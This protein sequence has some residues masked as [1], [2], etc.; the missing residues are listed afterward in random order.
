MDANTYNGK[1]RE[2][3]SEVGKVDRKWQ[4]YTKDDVHL[5]DQNVCHSQ[6]HEIAV[7]EES[8]QDKIF[9]FIYELDENI[10][11]DEERIKSLRSMSDELRKRVK[12]NSNEVKA[13]L[14]DLIKA[15]E[16]A[17]PM[18]AYEQQ[19]IDLKKNEH[20]ARKNEKSSKVK[21]K[22]DL[23]H[24]DANSLIAIMENATDVEEMSDQQIR[25]SILNDFKKWEDKVKELKKATEAIT[26][27]LAD[28]DL[29]VSE[30]ELVDNLHEAYQKAEEEVTKRI[31]SLTDKDS[32]LGLYTL[33]PSKNKETI[34]YPD[35]FCGR[36]GENVHKF[37]ADFKLAIQAD[38]VRSKD[39]VKT[40]IK[41]LDADA[42]TSIGEHTLKLEDA[43]DILKTT[44]GNPSLIWNHL[45]QN[46]S[47]SLG[48]SA[49]WGKQQSVERRNSITK[50]ID[51]LNE[52]KTLATEH[53]VLKTEINSAAT[54]THI[55][56]VIPGDIK[57]DITVKAKGTKT[58]D[59]HLQV[60]EEVL[61]DHREETLFRL[62]YDPHSTVTD[63]TKPPIKRKPS[64]NVSVTPQGKHDCS[65]GFQCKEEWGILGCIKLYETK[66]IDQRKTWLYNNKFC[67]R[68]GDIY[69]S[70]RK[71]RQK[72][73]C[74]WKDDKYKAKCTEKGCRFAA[75]VCKN[76]SNNASQDLLNWLQRNS[77]KFVAETIFVRIPQVNEFTQKGKKRNSFDAKLIDPSST[78]DAHTRKLLQEG[79]VS[80]M[81]NNNELT[82]LFSNDMRRCQKNATI[83]PIPEGDPVFIFCVFKGRKNDIM[84][85]IDCGANVWLAQDGIPQNELRSVKLR[86][87][88][89]PLGVASGI[90]TQAEAE[91][92]SLIPLA[93]GTFQ[94]VKGL[95]LKKVTSDMPQIDLN[96]ALD[97][98]KKDC[99]GDQRIKNLK[100]PKLVGGV[101]H[102]ILGIAYQAI[103]PVPLHSMPNG[104][105]LFK[106]KLLPSSSGMLACIGGPINILE[107]I[108]DSNGV[109][110]TFSYMSHLIQYRDQHK[111][112][113]EFFPDLKSS[114]LVDK[115][116]PGIQ[117]LV[118]P[119]Q[120]ES[121]YCSFDDE[122]S[123]TSDE[124][125]D[126]HKNMSHGNETFDKNTDTEC[127]PLIINSETLVCGSCNAVQS[128]MEKYM[129]TQDTGLSTGYKCQRCR[130]CRDCLKGP[131][132]E[133]MS[134][135]QE[136]EQDLI[137][138]SISID[139][140][141]GKAVAKLAFVEDPVSNLKPN[142]EVARKRAVNVDT[143]YSSNHEV[144]QM[145]CKS[146]KKLID[147]GHIIPW[148]NLSDIQRSRILQS[149]A[150]YFIP[151]DVSFKTGSLS[152]PA[153]CTFDA[154]SKTPGGTSLNQIL[155]KGDAD[156]ASLLEMM[157]SWVIGKVGFSADISQFYNS[158]LLDEE[159]WPYQQIV[160]YD[161]L[162]SKTKL[163]HGIVATC[164]YGVTCVGAQTEHVMELLADEIEPYYPE[165]AT[166]LRR[167]RYVDD[168]GQSNENEETV[169]RLINETEKSLL[170]R[171]MHIKGWVVSGKP[172]P[173]DLSED[174]ASVPF[175]GLVWFPEID[176]YK[177]NISS[178]HFSKKKRG[179]LPDNLVK[180]E[181][182][183]GMSIDEFTPKNL[184]RRM[185]TSVSARKFDPLGKAAPLDLR[186][187]N[188]LR[189]IIHFDSDWDKPIPP[190]LR[191][192]WC[193]NFQ[194]LEDIRD[195]SYVRCE[196]PSDALRQTVRLWLHCD[197]AEDGMIIVAHIGYEKSDGSWSCNHLIAKNL[198]SPSGWTTPKIELHALNAMANITAFLQN[199]LGEWIEDYRYASDSTI[200]ISW[201][202]YEKV[203]LKVFHRMRVSNIRNKIQLDNL[204]HIDGKFNVAD[205]GTRGDFVTADLLRPGGRWINGHEWM[206]LSV[207]EAENT[208][209]IKN[210]RDII[211]DNDMKRKMQEGSIHDDFDD[212]NTTANYLVNLVDAKKVAQV[213][214]E[215]N[216]IYS[217]LKRSF[218]SFIRITSYVFVACRKFKKKMMLAK[219]KRGEKVSDGSTLSDLNFPPPKFISYAAISANDDQIETDVKASLCYVFRTNYTV[220]ATDLNRKR[221]DSGRRYLIPRL[222][223]E[224]LSEALNYAYKKATSEVLKYHDKK[225]IE[226]RGIMIDGVLFCKT[227]ILE[228]QQLKI[229]GGLEDKVD[230][231]TL[232]GISFRVPLICKNSPLAIAIGYHLHYNVVKHM[233][234]ESTHRMSL[235]HVHIISGRS[236][237]KQINDECIYCKKLRTRYL[238]QIMGPLTD[239][240]LSVSP[241]YYY[242]YVDAFGPVKAFVPGY[243]RQTRSGHKTVDLLILTFCCAATSMVNLQVVEGGKTT[244]NFLEA[245]NRFFAENS[246][247]KVCFPDKDGALLKIMKESE[248]D[249]EDF[250]GI[251]SREKGMIFHTC[252]SQ[253]HS[254]HG[255]IE[256]KI[257][258]IQESLE[259]SGIK[260]RRLHALGWQTIAKQIEVQ[261]NSIPIG[262][263]MHDG[264]S[265]PL[266]KILRP[267]LLK[268]N[269]ASNRAPASLLTVPDRASDLFHKVEDVYNLWYKLYVDSYV[270]L[271][272]RRSK[273]L[274]EEENIQESD[275][276]YFKIRDSPLHS[277]WLIG[278][279]E[280]TLPSRD[281]KIRTVGI[282]YKYNTEGGEKVFKTV[283]RPVREIVKLLNIDDTCLLDDIRSVQNHARKLFDTQKLVTS[284]EIRDIPSV[285]D[286]DAFIA[287]TI[288]E[289]P[290][291]RDLLLVAESFAYLTS[292][293]NDA[294][295]EKFDDENDVLEW[296]FDPPTNDATDE[297]IA[298]IAFI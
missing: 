23:C 96:P 241:V 52:A 126:P 46:L 9:E 170:K 220:A 235:Q 91:W 260:N 110:N 61:L 156:L 41:Y 112:R 264:D 258:T 76:H 159:H 66:E 278:K 36:L 97:L 174:G 190:E 287:Y 237:F 90:T 111:Y 93:D 248:I 152:T 141:S 51:F 11:V 232:T 144:V 266:L 6:L 255:K 230:L 103:Y 62:T 106:S 132:R 157:L 83:R 84:T 243:E 259:R 282:G 261:V 35:V 276:V 120:D 10:E 118:E 197:G 137:R 213:E 161:G 231:H 166:L 293:S 284:D 92:S 198:L 249:V 181:G 188:D 251:L 136:K 228:G 208:G 151:W 218:R 182:S 265:R 29:D 85:F 187:K 130:D 221:F 116:I 125:F 56:S 294:S 21:T 109:G 3:K 16:E 32:K 19:S 163:R 200:A 43:F 239:Y 115:D 8:C 119:T 77:V 275:I 210:S 68:C 150:S 202:L 176:C 7:A 283:E 44:Y 102:M 134:I 80:K 177:L 273:W 173:T 193:E 79:K 217:P 179:R 78:M 142:M 146:L 39:E 270:P 75:A 280:Y 131:G 162:D 88:P 154:S 60:I 12:T 269:T 37:I 133:R 18:S 34:C 268:T 201:S 274:D 89:I 50:L 128:E 82:H 160:W 272:A 127:T 236:L 122:Y 71:V 70:G 247:P 252:P 233:G 138:K 100:V 155:A 246:V 289:A 107:H 256:A 45:K 245:F 203:K 297:E 194:I 253:G 195:I 292:S 168:F 64:A 192:R 186:L 184:T 65:K 164:I 285:P 288:R 169:K 226:K 14:T 63:E 149:K 135:K 215:S 55:F 40:L 124:A 123:D 27:D 5:C 53:E 205:F 277:S 72:H 28:L 104:L 69:V 180:Y 175:A 129:K 207:K 223:E 224:Q 209:V 33:A 147:R 26:I 242:T 58:I 140:T 17:K 291:K 219:M 31:K 48:K 67:T 171:D 214:S 227:R 4:G 95:T 105:T 167:R 74:S 38:H 196:I 298:E 113:M 101:V 212:T 254:S 15:A 99:P 30:Q 244:G 286:H 49:Y 279:V 1:L 59:Q 295:M 281:N 172:P 47:K 206:K 240:Q 148:E 178:L 238:R 211:L 158:I 145:I 57:K 13:R 199:A 262:Y 81:M 185:C 229:V 73:R 225:F 216:Y 296:P 183:F 117:D 189:K 87:G 98:I 94:C 271:L 20:I 143:K 263:L 139:K 165:V 42:K 191:S 108:C 290:I 267:N 222:N 234:S 22:I 24:K 54:I 257:K 86:D 25:M 114:A 250:G 2:I 121:P 204:Y 153:R